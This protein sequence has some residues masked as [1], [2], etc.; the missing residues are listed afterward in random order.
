MQVITAPDGW[1]LWTSQVRPGREHDATSLR[2]YLGLLDTLAACA[3]QARILGDLG[4]EGEAGTVTVAYKNPRTTNS[5]RPR[6][7]STRSTTGS[8]P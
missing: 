3:Q 8:D 6:S 1:P 2:A 7:N 5:P 4:Y